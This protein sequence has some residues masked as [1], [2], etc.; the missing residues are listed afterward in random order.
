M[1]SRGDHVTAHFAVPTLQLVSRTSN[2]VFG[3]ISSI[4]PPIHKDITITKSVTLQ[5]KIAHSKRARHMMRK[6]MSDIRIL[7]LWWCDSTP[8]CF[9]LCYWGPI[10]CAE[11]PVLVLQTLDKR[12]LTT[13]L[14]LI[15]IFSPVAVQQ[16]ILLFAESL[17]FSHGTIS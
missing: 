13:V 4:W 15:L 5:T 3:R 14:A 17:G 11:P 12:I 16:P 1:P 7:F 8:R 6:P 10:I 9:H 2:I